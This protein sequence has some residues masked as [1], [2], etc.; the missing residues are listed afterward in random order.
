MDSDHSNHSDE[1][2]PQLPSNGNGHLVVKK[3]FQVEN[4]LRKSPRLA[5]KVPH[6]MPSPRQKLSQLV[7]SS[8]KMQHNSQVSHNS[9]DQDYQEQ[10]ASDD[11]EEN[12]RMAR[13]GYFKREYIN[14][15]QGVDS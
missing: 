1:E 15:S 8:S 4:S 5:G 2:A 14:D 7:G 3:E 13:G 9:E 6:H 11:S 10:Y 12:P